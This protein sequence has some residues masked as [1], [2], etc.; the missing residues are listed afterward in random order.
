MKFLDG[1]YSYEVVLLVLGVTLFV[2]L[3]ILLAVLAAKGRPFAKLLGFFV[4]P[5]V[6]IGFPS[7]KSI[8]FSDGVAKIEKDTH[9]LQGDPTNKTLRD[10]LA[11]EVATLSPRPSSEP[12]VIA[13][14]A[15]AQIALGRNEEA[16]ASFNKASQLAPQHPQVLEV[17]KRLELDN[18]LADLAAKV[19]QQPS[20]SAAKEELQKILADVSSRPI[21]SPVTITNIARAQVAIGDQTQARLN[22]EKVLKINP[23]HAQAIQLRSKMGP[24]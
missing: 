22:V 21:A 12:G 1:L 10:A 2:A 13:T 9:D 18:K 15:H 3:L 24:P 23:N 14:I 16:R 5:I 20:N 6:M 17:Q 19:E 4:L 11:N 7:I 8:E